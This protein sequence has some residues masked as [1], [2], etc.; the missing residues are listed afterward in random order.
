MTSKRGELVGVKGD[1]RVMT[2]YLEEDYASVKSSKNNGLPS[3]S[4][5]AVDFPR[6]LL[7]MQL[8]D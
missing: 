8:I 3:D 2:S 5:W 4:W 7:N 6:K 1:W